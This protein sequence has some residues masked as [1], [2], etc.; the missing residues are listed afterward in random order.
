MDNVVLI[1][2]V[3]RAKLLDSADESCEGGRARRKAEAEAEMT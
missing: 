2:L 3:G 1:V